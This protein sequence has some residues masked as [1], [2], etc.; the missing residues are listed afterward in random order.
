LHLFDLCFKSICVLSDL[1][2]RP[3]WFYSD[4]LAFL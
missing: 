2:E 1:S 4:V 3:L